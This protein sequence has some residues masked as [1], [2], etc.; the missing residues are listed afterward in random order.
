MTWNRCVSLFR[1]FQ[2]PTVFVNGPSPPP[3]PPLSHVCCL[4]LVLVLQQWNI[5]TYILYCSYGCMAVRHHAH[6]QS[7]LTIKGCKQPTQGLPSW[8]WK[9][10]CTDRRVNPYLAGAR[11]P[12]LRCCLGLNRGNLTDIPVHIYIRSTIFSCYSRVNYSSRSRSRKIHE[13][14]PTLAKGATLFS[15]PSA[16]L[17]SLSA[18]AIHAQAV[19][20]ATSA[21]AVVLLLGC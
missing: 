9:R 19:R 10:R 6:S 1:L 18:I 3:P 7:T 20:R 14:N 8:G 15:V 5:H 12:W 21:A 13:Y 16:T 4:L 17:N 11:S 2:P